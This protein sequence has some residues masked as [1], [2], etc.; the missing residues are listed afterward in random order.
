MGCGSWNVEVSYITQ[1][2]MRTL[3]RESSLYFSKNRRFIKS[4]SYFSDDFWQKFQGGSLKKR[5]RRWVEKKERGTLFKKTITIRVLSGVAVLGGA[6]KYNQHVALINDKGGFG[7]VNS[8]AHELAHTWVNTRLNTY[9]IYVTDMV[10][11]HPSI[12]SCRG[13]VRKTDR[14]SLQY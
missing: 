8:A 5:S 9:L 14:I 4:L 2:Y 3:K 11:A 7:G 10:R 6:C 12:V 13:H 1:T